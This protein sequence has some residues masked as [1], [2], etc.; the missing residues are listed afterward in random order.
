[1]TEVLKAFAGG[2]WAFLVSW[3]LPTVA[4]AGLFAI[5]VYPQVPK[6]Y[7][8]GL[9]KLD[10]TTGPVA[11]GLAIFVLAFVTASFSQQLYRILEGYLI[12]P[13]FLQD[14]KIQRHRARRER[15]QL[16]FRSLSDQTG[17]RASLLLERLRQY[18]DDDR[19]VAPT[20]FGNSIRALE[21]YA[22]DRYDLNTLVL[23]NDLVASAP[24]SLQK[25]EETARASVNFFVA[26]IYWS[27]VLAVV[28]LSTFVAVS[29][30]DSWRH[31]KW[32][33]LLVGALGVLLPAAFYGAAVGRC[34]YW[35]SAVRALVNTGR[36]R[37]AAN[38]GLQVPDSIEQERAMWR[39]ASSFVY[40]EYGANRAKRLD[41]YRIKS[42]APPPVA[43]EKPNE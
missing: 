22:N 35:F 18:P 31:P 2:S 6:D 41:Q 3:L 27:V 21:M 5:V 25:E 23:W 26:M 16:T 4:A 14:W 28:S 43:A 40:W 42:V 29:L 1:M 20:L 11:V 36:I 30:P 13:G 8:T 39:A 15:L 33:L 12:W 38:L 32:Q 7:T 37:L 24:D 19:Q 9:L 17:L 10:S 34:V